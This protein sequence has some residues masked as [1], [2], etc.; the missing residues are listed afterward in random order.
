MEFE[1]LKNFF[2]NR[3]VKILG[4]DKEYKRYAV[5]I[6]IYYDGEYKVLFEVRSHKLNFQPGDISFPGGKVEEGETPKEAAIREL[7]EE[8]GLKEEHIEFIGQFDTLVTYHGKII[9]VFVVQIKEMDFNPSKDEVHELFFVPVDFFLRNNPIIKNA[10][11]KAYFE[12]EKQNN[13]GLLESKTPIYY[14]KYNNKIIWG[15]T[16]K[17]IYY[18]TMEFLQKYR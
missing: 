14:Y 7:I 8:V 3:E 18:F 4:E 13:K 15:I 12:D 1:A 5:T 17:I 9:Y 16:A 2:N 6:P 11:L 10:N